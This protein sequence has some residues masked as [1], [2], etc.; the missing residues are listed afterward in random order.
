MQRDNSNGIGRCTANLVELVLEHN[1]PLGSLAG[2]QPSSDSAITMDISIREICSILFGEEERKKIGTLEFR[3]SK[4]M[5]DRRGCSLC[6]I[7][8]PIPRAKMI[9]K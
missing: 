5:L 3:R 4:Q 8:K 7:W 9:K 6:A 2:I 1:E